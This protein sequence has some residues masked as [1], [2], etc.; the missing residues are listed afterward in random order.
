MRQIFIV[1]AISFF[2]LGGASATP[3]D[4]LV[5]VPK[6]LIPPVIDGQMD[7]VWK[8]VTE[9]HMEGWETAPSDD[10][11]DLYSTWRMMWDEENIYL[12]YRCQDEYIEGEHTNPWERDSFEF[13]FDADNSKNQD[14]TGYDG[15]DDIQLRVA[16][17][18]E[19]VDEIDAWFNNTA[20]WGFIR[21][22]IEFKAIETD[23]GWQAEVKMPM[24]NVQLGPEPGW[25]FGFE[26]QSNDNDSDHR[27]TI[28]HWM[29]GGDT[30]ASPQLWGTCVLSNLVV[31]EQL[32]VLA[33]D[34]T[35][36]IDGVLD[37]GW[38]KMPVYTSNSFAYD[39]SAAE[40]WD[41]RPYI[42]YWSD[43]YFTFQIGWDAEKLY[44]FLDKFDD[45]IVDEHA[46]AWEQDGV[47][48]F[49]DGDHSQGA[50]YDGANDVQIRFNHW[51]ATTD[52]ITLGYGT[53]ADWG[54]PKGN[55]EFAVGQADSGF[56]IEIAMPLSDLA[57]PIKQ[58]VL[59]GFEIQSNDNDGSARDAERKWWSE[60]NHSWDTPNLWGT[61]M[62][63]GS[64]AA[65]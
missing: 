18:Y 46:N 48:L 49:V 3:V 59:F 38:Q 16:V 7:D 60:N 8:N 28:G 50:A 31:A 56:T 63:Q 61:C 13:Y 32:P 52:D 29:H 45:A 57:I 51:Y 33:V 11:Y 37:A 20:D 12:F 25:E 55:V 19:T 1:F 44:I 34:F 43:H 64:P 23:L 58:G 27:E 9:I 10:W 65:V 24:Y 15:V 62:L 21:D 53:G 14:G 39:V 30:H 42:N 35:P 47:E 41:P 5:E 2:L 22:D 4:D 40:W 6:V 36:V 54:F 17:W 26:V